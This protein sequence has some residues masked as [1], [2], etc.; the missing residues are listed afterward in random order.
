M[1]ATDGFWGECFA[2]GRQEADAD[3]GADHVSDEVVD[4]GGA[5]KAA[6]DQF[7][8]QAEDQCDGQDQDSLGRKAFGPFFY[9]RSNKQG[10]QGEV[11][12]VADVPEG[13]EMAR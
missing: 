1:Q 5:L 8:Q 7:D 6:L 12:D 11:D 10:K 4:V 2:A 3:Q 13:F 9:V